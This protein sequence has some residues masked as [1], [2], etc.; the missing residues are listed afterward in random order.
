MNSKK[1]TQLRKELEC[2]EFGTIQAR[3]HKPKSYV[4]KEQTYTKDND[5]HSSGHNLPSKNIL[6]RA[7]KSKNGQ[8]TR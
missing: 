4:L 5:A 7:G 3:R 1:H 2:K 6:G 8:N